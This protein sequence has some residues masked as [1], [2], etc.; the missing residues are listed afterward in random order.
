MAQDKDKEAEAF[1]KGLIPYVAFEA[2]CLLAGIGAQIMTG[3]VLWLVLGAVVG[4]APL[5]LYVF[6]YSQ[7]SGKR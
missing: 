7:R 4:G 5:L 3:Q 2:V 1:G 6:R